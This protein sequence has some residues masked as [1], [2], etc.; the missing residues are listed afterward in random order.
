MTSM[1]RIAVAFVYVL[2]ATFGLSQ[3]LAARPC[4]D[5]PTVESDRVAQSGSIVQSDSDHSEYRYLQLSN[6][7]QVLLVSDKK[8]TRP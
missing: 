7:M 3:A 5:N 8:L 6:Q 2:I 4:H 1:K